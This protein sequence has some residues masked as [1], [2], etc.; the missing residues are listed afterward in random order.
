M[1]KVVIGALTGA[2]FFTI[3]AVALAV[4]NT[5]SYTTTIKEKTKPKP[6]KPANLGYTATLDVGTTD[7]TQPDGASTN[8]IFLAKGYITNGKFFPSCKQS[9]IDGKTTVPAKCKKA[10]IGT[11]VASSKS[12]KP[13]NP[14]AISEDL[15]VTAYNGPKGKSILLA[16]TN[17]NGPVGIT[18]RVIPG[19]L[20]AGGSGFAFSVTFKTP[21]D[22]QQQLGVQIALTHFKVTIPSSKTVKVKG[23]KVSYLQLASCPK[24]KKLATKAVVHFNND[25]GSPGGPTVT[26]TG[27]YA[28]T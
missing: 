6:G 24:S 16:V 5:V 28:C 1:R 12:G 4:T 21:P 18:N 9:D 22:L 17:T 2:C 8:E 26:A 10:V 27:V 7:G 14:P 11:G 19:T 15:K 20:G 3:V 23:N 13:G 25:D